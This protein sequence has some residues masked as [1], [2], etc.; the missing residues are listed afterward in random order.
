MRNFKVYSRNHVFMALHTITNFINQIHIYI[1]QMY[2]MSFF[3]MMVKM[4]PNSCKSTI[5]IFKK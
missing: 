3:S 1:I 4:A 2:G 5:L